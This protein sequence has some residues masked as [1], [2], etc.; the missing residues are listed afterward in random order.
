MEHFN[1]FK[2]HRGQNYKSSITVN[3]L[4]RFSLVLRLTLL[5]S[6]QSE[7]GSIVILGSDSQYPGKND[8]EKFP[9]DLPG[10]LELLVHPAPDK[11]GE[12]VGRG[13]QRFGFSK[14][15]AI[16]GIHKLNKRLFKN[17]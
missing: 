9:P 4:A 11:S 8:L 3:H 14:A 2:V 7:G 5:G 12:D 16:M 6:F 10:D 13:F 15:G 17:L 1:V